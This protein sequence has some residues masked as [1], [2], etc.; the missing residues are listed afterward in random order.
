MGR[1]IDADPMS[2]ALFLATAM[3]ISALP[4][5]ARTLMDLN[6]YHTD[7]GM[8]V[9]SAAI[10]NDL[11]GWTIFALILGMLGTRTAGFGVAWT[12][13]LTLSFCAVML[14]LG[15][16]LINRSLPFL[17]AY[18]HWP[19]GAL[20]FIVTPGLFG[21]AF[22]EFI[23]I[24]AI[25]GSFIVGIAIGA[26][27]HM[28]ERTR[29]LLEEFVSFIFAPV[30][31]ASIGLKVNFVTHFDLQLVT[32]MLFLA[33]VGKFAGAVAGARWGGLAIRE[34]WGY[35]HPGSISMHRM[36]RPHCCIFAVDRER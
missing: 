27:R 6:L 4:V 18:A 7:I 35:Q 10:F 16:W 15:R 31:F 17:Q 5:I 29:V 20:G 25:F 12:I 28:H 3:S 24:H 26:S 9:V 34:S 23:G 2:F 8:I 14:T 1:E 19:A 21:A 22:T 33:C 13:L 11:L 32:L 30:F 36:V